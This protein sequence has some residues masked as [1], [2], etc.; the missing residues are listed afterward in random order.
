MRHFISTPV[1]TLEILIDNEMVAGIIFKQKKSCSKIKTRHPLLKR[2]QKQLVEYF[3]GKRTHFD[4]P[5]ELEGTP[6]Q[7]K[8]WL[9][10]IKIP[11]G[12]T[13]SYSELARR[14]GNPKACRAV[15]QANNKNPIPL[16]IPCHRVIGKNGDLVG[17]AGRLDVKKWLLDHERHSSNKNKFFS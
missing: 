12:T 8:V 17:F 1:G 14:I 6:F 11:F 9:E 5:I 13:I 3:S 2:C 15:G 4:L 16:I 10:L 7:K